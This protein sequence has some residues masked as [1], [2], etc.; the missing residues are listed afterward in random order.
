MHSGQA[1]LRSR[2]WGGMC[3]PR[4]AGLTRPAVVG[5]S[6]PAERMSVRAWL[7]PDMA[8]VLLP[9][10]KNPFRDISRLVKRS[11]LGLLNISE[12]SVGVYEI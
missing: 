3:G 11:A 7:H 12:V 8:L 10:G 1:V 6:R 2:V 4:P 9:E 5:M